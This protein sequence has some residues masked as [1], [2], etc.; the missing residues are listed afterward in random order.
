MGSNAYNNAEEEIF[1]EM[2]QRMAVEEGQRAI[3]ENE[4]LKNDPAAAMP[5]S[6]HK[7]CMEILK[8]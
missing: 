6:L 3:E 7:K 5:E 1:A 4:R 2:M 8:G